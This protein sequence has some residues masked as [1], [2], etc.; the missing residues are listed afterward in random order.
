[1]VDDIPIALFTHLTVL[2][3]PWL[4]ILLIVGLLASFILLEGTGGVDLLQ[5]VLA[6]MLL[7]LIPH[8]VNLRGPIGTHSEVINSMVLLPVNL[9][10]QIV[11]SLFDVE[12]LLPGVSVETHGSSH[13]LKVEVS[14]TLRQDPRKN[15]S[16]I[17]V[18][19]VIFLLIPSEAPLISL[20]NGKSLNPILLD[21]QS[22]ETIPILR[23]IILE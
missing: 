4:P 16:G 13:V 12:I 10:E 17:G 8:K 18:V 22:Y 15:Q 23:L 9:H 3:D 6:L 7:V 14:I 21:H 20:R 5:N 11:L 2:V 19:V 1:V